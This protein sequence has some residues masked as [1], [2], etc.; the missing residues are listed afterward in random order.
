[1]ACLSES[2]LH[3]GINA[4]VQR[5]QEVS[6]HRSEEVARGYAGRHAGA[7]RR[8]HLVSRLL[9]EAAVEP[10][11]RP[12]NAPIAMARVDAAL[13]AA[14]DPTVDGRSLLHELRFGT[15]ADRQDDQ[16]ALA[17]AVA[18]A[19][20]DPAEDVAVN[21]DQRN[22]ASLR[23]YPCGARCAETCPLA[24]RQKKCT[25]KASCMKHDGHRAAC[26]SNPSFGVPSGQRLLT[27][28]CPPVG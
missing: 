24:R 23:V 10:S 9:Q 17:E 11:M 21:R 12:A 18:A 19:P 27:S 3:D 8:S 4:V 1:M 5:I 20:D 7:S 22:I 25:K 15:S 13:D 28:F 16:A 2:V 6:G 14:A 26:N